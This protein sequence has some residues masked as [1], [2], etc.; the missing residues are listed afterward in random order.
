MVALSAA[1]GGALGIAEV[2][3][4]VEDSLAGR[5]ATACG[6]HAMSTASSRQAGRQ[7]GRQTGRQAG[8]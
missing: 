7:A 2:V 6:M 1:V 3:E 4:T 8:R 5:P